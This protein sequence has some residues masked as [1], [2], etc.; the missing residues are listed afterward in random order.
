MQAALYRRLTELI[1]RSRAERH[2]SRTV[3]VHRLFEALDWG[4]R[5]AFSMAKHS[6]E[7]FDLTVEGCPVVSVLSQAPTEIEAVYDVLNR[8]YNRD[9]S[10]VVATD[11]RSLGLFG[12]YWFSFAHDV[13]N[14]LAW[15]MDTPDFLLDVPKLD[16]LTP[17]EVASSRLDQVYDS[18]PLRKRRHPI[19]M[20]LVER[21]SHWRDMALEALGPGAEE[22]DSLVHRLINSLFLV[23]Y[24]EDSGRLPNRLLDSIERSR[25][26]VNDTIGE[27]FRDLRTSTNY[28]TLTKT[29]LTRLAA[30]PLKTLV[31]QLYGYEEWGVRYDFSEM[32]VDI[33]G[34]FYEEYLRLKPRRRLSVPKKTDPL[35]LFDQPTHEFDDVRR[36][37]GI[38]YTPGF[39]VHHIVSNLI[40]RHEAS[41]ADTCPLVVDLAC[42]SGTFLVAALEDMATRRQWRARAAQSIVG[43]DSDGRAV[44]AARLNL[45]AKCISKGLINPVP[46]LGLLEYDL[47]AEGTEGRMIQTLLPEE[48]V[49]IVVGNPPYIKY[50]TLSKDYDSNV[51]KRHFDLGS[52]RTDSYMLFVEASMKLLKPGGFCGLVLP[53]PFLQSSSAG[54]LR[55]WVSEHADVLEIVDFQD[56]P[57]FQNVGV[58][59][60]IVLF[61]K[62]DPRNP[63]PH[64]AVGKIYQ[65]SATPSAQLAKLSVA[66]ELGDETQEVF[67]IA[68][69][70]TSKPWVLRNQIEQAI[71]NVMSNASTSL[72]E[73][74]LEIC[75]GVKTGA[76]D[77]FVGEQDG[78]SQLRSA[79]GGQVELEIS[80]PFLRS[81]D[82][83]RWFTRP[84]AQLIYPYDR[85]TT[86]VMPWTRLL[87][88]F[89]KCAAYLEAHRPLL[90]S[91]KSLKNENWYE[92]IRPR[93]ATVFATDQRLFIGE[94]SL[95]PTV[96]E[97]EGINT[98]IAGSTGGGSWIVLKNVQYDKRS[99]MAYLNSSVVEW[100]LRQVASVRRGGW[101]VIEQR[102]LE[103][104]LL[105]RF[106]AQPQSFARSEL[107]R[108]AERATELA[109]ASAGF[110]SSEVRQQIAS[111]EDQINSLIIEALGLSAAQAD[112]VRKRVLA[113][114]GARS[115]RENILAIF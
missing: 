56:Q 100:S 101:L 10:W 3:W 65:L 48:G 7:I 24:L 12:S 53:T 20:H 112:Y 25:R 39:L 29:E 2:V 80:I 52:Q 42:G 106:L 109:R 44:E 92:L 27:A 67:H 51:L 41:C 59:V 8:A 64:V 82:L 49:D 77:V 35:Y 5:A 11:F 50:E 16:L 34:R 70:R 21:M 79:F 113:L 88:E 61:R 63:P 75:Q 31:R 60:C 32:G 45:V 46:T 83:K 37:K 95:R 84:R 15:R 87:K 57:V 98:A 14:A 89:P 114:R 86:R 66:E 78:K 9:I 103:T 38:F 23:R 91:R 115:D 1:D 107:I 99:L 62:R 13:T 105:P 72:G 74:G 6:E 85:E 19:D 58:Y 71:L 4:D 81:R 28:P 40:R 17:Q 68:Q 111:V 110:Q 108:L 30:A 93:A 36:S 69:P 54:H 26:E 47:L 94:L 102:V 104:I 90:T 73:S 76:D 18:F 43:L 96:T 33:L 22:D 97:S 55:A